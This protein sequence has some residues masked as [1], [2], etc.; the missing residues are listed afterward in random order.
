MV[1]RVIDERRVHDDVTVVGQEQVSGAGLEQLD[2]GVGHAVGSP[3]DGMVD[4]VL[5]LVLQGRNAADTGKLFAQAPGDQRLEQP[6]ERSGHAREAEVGEDI[7]ECRV[8]EQACQNGRDLSVVVRSDGI[9]FAHHAL[10]LETARV[11]GR[12]GVRKTARTRAGPVN[13]PA[14]IRTSHSGGRDAGNCDLRL[15][16]L[17]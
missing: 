1:H 7:E 15:P 12:A 9:E 11:I 4:V 2:A 3:L 5:D 17:W 6:A 8:A 13:R 16:L 10:L 14:I